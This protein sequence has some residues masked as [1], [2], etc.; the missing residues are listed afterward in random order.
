MDALGSL[1]PHGPFCPV[2]SL[3]YLSDIRGP[4]DTS[5]SPVFFFSDKASL[6]SAHYPE[7]HCVNQ[8]GL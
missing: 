5:G 6:C 7:I 3:V 8:G 2:T 1:D 4:M